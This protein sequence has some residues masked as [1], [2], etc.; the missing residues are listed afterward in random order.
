MSGFSEITLWGKNLEES[1]NMFGLTASDLEKKIA[2]FADGASS[3]NCELTRMGKSIISLDPVY[4]FPKSH[5]EAC[6]NKVF[7]QSLVYIKELP[8]KEQA[9]LKKIESARKR[10]AKLFL[11][12]YETGKKEGRYIQY[13]LPQKTAFANLS[14]DLGLC[15]NF[16]L[17]Y[18][19]LGI[20]FHLAALTEMLRVCREVRIFPV[21]NTFGHI[22]TILPPLTRYFEN[23]FKIDFVSVSCGYEQYQYKMLKIGRF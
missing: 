7:K 12:D 8:G 14:F 19:E 15:S 6:F 1:K 9:K 5:L 4:S 21:I 23:F 16:I 20:D 13:S 18:E 11:E 22:S 2:G 17:L 10:T 3:L